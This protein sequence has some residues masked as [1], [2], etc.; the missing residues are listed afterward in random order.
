MSQLP[1]TE[2]SSN[3]HIRSDN[4]LRSM[5]KEDMNRGET[6]QPLTKEEL[7]KEFQAFVDSLEIRPPT[8]PKFKDGDEYMTDDDDDK[9]NR[10]AKRDGQRSE[11]DLECDEKCQPDDPYQ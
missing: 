2:N 11:D 1:G 9:E 5:Q 4:S 7:D 8:P 10:R 3:P 6:L